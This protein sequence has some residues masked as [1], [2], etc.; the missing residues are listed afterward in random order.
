MG[1]LLKGKSVNE[2]GELLDDVNIL[3]TVTIILLEVRL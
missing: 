3:P 2:N 1:G